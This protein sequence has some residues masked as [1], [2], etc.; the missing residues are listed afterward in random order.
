M[1]SNF[2]KSCVIIFCFASVSVVGQTPVTLESNSP[3]E[4]DL[5]GGERHFYQIKAQK[6]DFIRV[7]V[8]QRNADVRLELSDTQK[9]NETNNSDNREE[10]EK[11]SFIADNA[12]EFRIGVSFVKKLGGRGQGKGYE[13][14]LDNI[15]PATGRDKTLIAAERLYDKA[16]ALRFET[17]AESKR[18]ALKFF[19][20]SIPLFSQA[21]DKPGLAFAH[22]ALAQTHGSLSEFAPSREN[23]VKSAQ[24]FRELNLRPQLAVTLKNQAAIHFFEKD[25]KQS[26]SLL[27]EVQKIYQEL[28]DRRGEAEIISNFGAIYANQDQP[29]KALD[30]YLRALPLLE[31]EGDEA[32]VTRTLSNIGSIYDDLGEP[33]A[34]LENY[35]RALALRRK[36]GDTR[37]EAYTLANMA[38]VFKGLG[39]LQRV[40]EASERAR[41]IF[42][43]R[44]EKYGEAVCFNNLGTAYNDLNDNERAIEFY[45]KALALNRELKQRDG[46]AANLTNIATIEMQN[47]NLPKAQQIYAQ[48]LQIYRET[49]NKRGETRA[50]VKL[51]DAYQKSGNRTDALNFFNQALPILREIEDREWESL[52]LFLIGEVHRQNG[53]FTV[54]REKSLQALELQKEIREQLI[55]AIILLGLART[56]RS[57]QNYADAQKYIENAL[58]IVE[59]LRSKL[60]RQDFRASYFSSKMEYYEL[61]IDLLI[62]R[63]M[64]AEALKVSERARARNLLESLGETQNNIRAGVSPELL[65]KERFLR[66]TM[67]AKDTLRLNA[68]KRKENAKAGALEKELTGLLSQYRNLEDEIRA[69]SPQFSALIYP[70]VLNPAQIQAEVLDADTVLLEYFLGTERSYLFFVTKDKIEVHGLPP[71]AEIEKTARKFL[72]GLRARGNAAAD[73][74]PA[75]YEQRLEQAD[76]DLENSAEELSRIILSPVAGKLTN[77]RLLVVSSGVLQYVPFSS[78]QNPSGL[79]NR[80]SKLTAGKSKTEPRFLIETNEIVNLPSASLLAVLRKAQSKEAAKNTVAVLADPVF[81]SDDMRLRTA[82]KQKSEKILPAAL[83]SPVDKTNS[84]IVLP[85]RRLRSDFARL[86]FSRAEAEAISAL[87][88]DNKKIIALDFNANLQTVNNIELQKSRVIHFSTHGFVNSDFPELSGVVLSLVDENGKTQD[89]FLRLHDIYNLRLAADL[90]V[91]SACETALG[92]EIK[93]EG[94][95]SLTRGFMYAG[96]PRVVASLWKVNDRATAI[97]M[98]RFYQKMLNENLPPASALRA[99]QISVLQEKSTRHPFYWAAFTLQG[100]FR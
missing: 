78:L 26:V 97:L 14:R 63:G 55:E 47:G 31:A 89:G 45:E 62:K 25:L 60:S 49:K 76:N 40:I 61:Y 9:L 21:E 13:I 5:T 98:R 99:A 3:V 19:N 15:R 94:V 70:E 53:D 52:T 69:K 54:A 46:E 11:I 72:N 83:N 91:L 67:N 86:H 7:V 35:E 8:V 39:D 81:S 96:S 16:N 66:Q 87:V 38:L 20:E 79:A 56:E 77:K 85:H 36:L 75:L 32:S 22:F 90:V 100:D 48:T 64:T 88:P 65:E 93:G 18:S 34:S 23:F 12:G 43:E 24:I 41:Q 4:R 58:G 33:K 92:K 42:A 1:F 74:T 73:E 51:G 2:W 71:Q 6:G 28:G 95:I 37:G 27:E 68:L 80:T 10:N 57:L 59:N 17:K 30:F 82:A 50:L 84:K 29:R 44:G